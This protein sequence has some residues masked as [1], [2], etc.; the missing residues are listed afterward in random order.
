VKLD[1]LFLFLIVGRL[2]LQ[3]GPEVVG[4]AE[5]TTLA[6]TIEPDVLPHLILVPRAVYL[7]LFFVTH[8]LFER[9]GSLL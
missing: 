3:I 6:T 8:I 5:T 2:L 7:G 4:P 9:P 1:C